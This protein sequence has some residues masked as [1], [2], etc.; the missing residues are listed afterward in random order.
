M[1]I[2]YREISNISPKL[3]EVFPAFLVGLY[4]GKAY[5]RGPKL[6]FQSD[7]AIATF[8]LANEQN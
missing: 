8:N 5:I 1:F 3:I 2:I 4:S 7:R 6:S